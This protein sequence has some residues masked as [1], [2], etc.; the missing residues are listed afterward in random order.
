[1][2]KTEQAEDAIE[3]HFAEQLEAGHMVA[4]E[5][6]GAEYQRTEPDVIF[7]SPTADWG[8]ITHAVVPNPKRRWWSFWRPRVLVQTIS[9]P[10]RLSNYAVASDAAGGTLSPEAVMKKFSA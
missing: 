8:T 3:R 6:S 5:V 7:P 9:A 1:M 4:R 2:T 10:I